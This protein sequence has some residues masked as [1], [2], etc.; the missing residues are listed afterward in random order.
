MCAE[1]LSCLGELSQLAI[2]STVIT[3]IGSLVTFVFEISSYKND[4][5]R[6]FIK[7]LLDNRKLKI[8][9]VNDVLI[10]DVK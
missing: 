4:L 6:W 5:N 1:S 10:E 7:K 9:Q 8:C 2:I 3:G